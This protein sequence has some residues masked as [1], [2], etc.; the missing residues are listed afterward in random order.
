MAGDKQKVTE[1][2]SIRQTAAPPD[3]QPPEDPRPIADEAPATPEPPKPGEVVRTEGGMDTRDIVGGNIKETVN[4]PVTAA[5]KD[6]LRMQRL[7]IRAS[8]AAGTQKLALVTGRPLDEWGLL[9]EGD[10]VVGH[11]VLIDLDTLEKIEVKEEYTVEGDRVL[12]NSQQI[13]KLIAFGDGLK[14]L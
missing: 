3:D 14:Q 10:R 6:R 1:G 7:L 8:K 5:P 12:A 2:A 11:F 9:G 4:V 13:P